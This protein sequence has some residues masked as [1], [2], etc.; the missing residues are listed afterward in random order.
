M[1]RK[2]RN[3]KEVL[4]KVLLNSI[5]KANLKSALSAFCRARNRTARDMLFQ[6]HGY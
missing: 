1:L 5:L 4:R 2:G 3:N 6:L